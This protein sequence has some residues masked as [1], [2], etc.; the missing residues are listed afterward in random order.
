MSTALRTRQALPSAPLWAAAMLLAACGGG[1]GMGSTPTSTGADVTPPG[2]MGSTSMDTMCMGM[3]GMYGSMSC[4]APTIAL[5]APAGTVSRTV[6]LRAHVT[7]MEG[8]VASRVDFMLDGARIGTASS[9]PF[10]VSW[11]STTV[12]DG[13]HTLTATVSDSLGQATNSSPVAIQVDNHPAF[14]VALSAAQLIPTPTSAASALAHL[15]AKLATGEL[16]GSVVLAG[17]TATAVTVNEAFAGDHGPVLIA[18]TP[19]ASSAEWDLPAG[20]LLTAEQTTSLLQGGLYVMASSMAN[21]GGELRGQITPANIVVTFSAMSGTQE[22]PPVTINAAGSAAT[23]VDQVANTLT[24]H[25]H[26]TGI[27]DAMA[28]EVAEGAPGTTGGRL[29]ALSKDDLDPGHWSAQLV[30]VGGEDIAA[31]K[32]D[33]WYV[34]VLTPTDPAGAIR[35]QIEPAAH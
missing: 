30:A 11:D 34:N 20:A 18:L 2:S 16:T 10:S 25:V 13:S 3:G 23:T 24:V 8:D 15:S 9:E 22:V 21:P 17:M 33:H 27:D 14:T 5:I 19:G 31:F 12:S 28:G 26:A 35:G 1:G 6:T 4:P 29:T 7:V 32:A